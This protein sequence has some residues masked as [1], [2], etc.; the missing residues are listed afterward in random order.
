MRAWGACTLVLGVSGCATYHAAPLD[1]ARAERELA[2]RSLDDPDLTVFARQLSGSDAPFPPAVWTVDQLEL[3]ALYLRAELREALAHDAVAAAAID[4]A[5]Q[6]PN[7]SL[8]LAVERVGNSGSDSAPWLFGATPSWTFETADKRELRVSAAEIERE[9]SRVAVERTARRLAA[10]VE[11]A[12]AGVES[13]RRVSAS[14]RTA[15]ES[16]VARATL[17]RRLVAAGELAGPDAT[18]AELA[19]SEA[20]L[21]VERARSEEAA[22]T[23][24]LARA[25]GVDPS[26]LASLNLDPTRELP[27]APSSGDAR[28]LGLHA[29]TE[30]RDA[31]LGFEAAD[32]E[33]RRAVASQYPDVQ[34]SPGFTWDQG[35]RK[36]ALGVS[37]ELP[38]FDDHRSAIALASA[39]REEA[40]ASF[41]TVQ[42]DVIAEIEARRSDYE[43]AQVELDLARRAAVAR[44]A[45]TNAARAR[46]AAGEADRLEELDLVFEAARADV[47][48]ARAEQRARTA[49]IE[50]ERAL[51]R[52]LDAVLKNE[53]D[54]GEPQ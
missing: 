15:A 53:H 13:A 7:P 23:H 26:A 50:L 10:E 27:P 2:A 35:E 33:L 38:L 18:A 46:V 45:R 12:C 54:S 8:A 52:R 40:R 4:V 51:G 14:A 31:A 3:A 32:V 29:R 47:D 36:F 5:D 28:A 25:I 20:A 39:R 49:R 37:F 24:A 42:E 21:E 11:A 16:S 17:L 22:A 43:R 44:D 30:L 41:A 34:L 9:K 19:A 48:L 1:P 6:R